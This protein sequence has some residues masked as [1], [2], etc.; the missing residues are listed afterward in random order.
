MI[1]GATKRRS[2]GKPN[3]LSAWRHWWAAVTFVDALYR[4]RRL[5]VPAHHR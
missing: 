2:S 1:S 5:D 3:L 4:S